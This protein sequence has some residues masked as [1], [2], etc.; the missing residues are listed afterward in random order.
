M[1]VIF[2]HRRDLRVLD[3]IG[4]YEAS[5]VGIVYPVFVLDD[6][7]FENY[8]VC[9]SRL[10]FLKESLEDLN[11]QYQKLGSSLIFRYGNP[12][13]ILLEMQRELNAEVF[14]NED[15]NTIYGLQRDSKA[16][17][18]GFKF[19]IN[20]AIQR[21]GRT[22]DWSERTLKYFQSEI[23]QIKSLKPH[24]YLVAEEELLRIKT[25]FDSLE[26]DKLTTEKGGS[27]VAESR[28]NKFLNLV[29]DYPKN[30]S[31]PFE[32]ETLTSRLSTHFSFGT[33]STKFVYQ[34]VNSLNYKNKHFFISRLFW[35][36]HFTQKLADNP[37]LT[38]KPANPIFEIY[39][40]E[41]YEYNEEIF[42]AWKEGRTGYLLVD[43]SMR[44]L[45]KTGFLNFRMRAMVASF[46]TYILKQPWKLGADYMFS[47]LIDADVA[48]NYSQ[49]QMQSGMVGVHP[50][51]IY[52]PTKQILEHDP[53]LFFI[54][55][56][57]PEVQNLDD[58]FLKK[59][60]E[61][62]QIS[63]FESYY[64]PP[65]VSFRERSQWARLIYSKITKIAFEKVKKDLNLQKK[66]SL[67]EVSKNRIQKDQLPLT[68]IV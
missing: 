15:T 14:V 7:F 9:R 32:A 33:I 57:L 4:L 39:Y 12:L 27:S 62:I 49:W 52:N 1:N 42:N 18:M 21:S 65:I 35:N 26:H 3:N 44:A 25:L 28:L 30:I 23:L 68:K 19:F 10:V 60:P 17:S 36:Q 22:S 50:N 37:E 48:I 61:S 46:L 40:N 51:R 58:N 8:N 47:Q 34:K 20:D 6:F 2:W 41:I 13:K 31:K 24:K 67:E 5:K 16:K 63:F 54:K 59:D 29:K 56:Y 45:K 53:N 55:K 64:Y 66:L 11:K 38:D 43:A